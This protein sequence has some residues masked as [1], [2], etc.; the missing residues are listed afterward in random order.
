M[1]L[2]SFFVNIFEKRS[3]AP[4]CK[5]IQSYSICTN[6]IR[7]EFSQKA[8]ARKFSIHQPGWGVNLKNEPLQGKLELD[9]LEA[10]FLSNIAHT[11]LP[12]Y[13]TC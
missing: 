7:I 11:S 3:S 12:K 4:L 1:L 9:Q 5:Q 10:E 2:L 13:I 6:K 8:K